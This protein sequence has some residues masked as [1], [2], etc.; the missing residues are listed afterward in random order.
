M[1][2]FSFFFERRFMREFI[3]NKKLDLL[4]LL[5]KFA[6]FLIKGDRLYS[7]FYSRMTSRINRFV[8]DKNNMLLLG[9]DTELDIKRIDISLYIVN[10]TRIVTEY[11]LRNPRR[12]L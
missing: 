5:A 10:T 12:G 3:N 7:F 9:E 8:M 1:G 6:R 2:S 11:L 4:F